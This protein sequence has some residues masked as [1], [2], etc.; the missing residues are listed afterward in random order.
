MQASN[1]SKT[2]PR[3]RR[4]ARGAREFV[5]HALVQDRVLKKIYPGIMHFLL[6]WGVT[7]QIL[8]TI[9]NLLQQ[10]LFL[11]FV[12]NFPRGN[13]YLGF[14][15]IMDIAGG[16]ILL[17]GLMALFRRVA[18]RPKTLESHWDDWYAIGLLLLIPILGFSSEGFRILVTQPEWR[19]WAPIGNLFAKGFSAIH[20]EQDLINPVHQ[21]L[22]WAH[23]VSGLVFVGSIPFTKLRH[24]VNGPLNIVLRPERPAAALEPIENIEEAEKLGVGEVDEFQPFLM[25]NFDA[26]VQCGRCEEVCPSN[27]S[28]MPYSP[29]V[30]IRDIRE[31]VH[32]T[33]I[34]PDGDEGPA[35]LNGALDK[36]IPWYCTTCGACIEVCPLF[37]NPVDS[38]IELRRYLTLTTGEIPGAVGEALMGMERRG[39]PWSMP[40]ENHAPW[41]KEL[42]V[43]ILQPGDEVDVLLFIGCAFG[44]DTRSQKAG[45]ELARILQRAGVDFGV[46]GP[47]EVCCGETAR[48]LGH[49]Y[50]FQVMVEENIATFNSVS[51]NSMVTAC[52]HC[53][54]TLKNEYPQFGG[55]YQV[56]HHTEL[57]AELVRE[58]RIKTN[59]KGG[60][61][62]FSYHDS[63]YL[64]RYNKIFD[65]PRQILHSIPGL[66][67]SEFPRK[68]QNAFC[69]GG[70]GGH[71]W[72]E[73]DPATRINHRRLEEVME[74]V[75]ADTI[76]TACPYCLIM[77]EDAINS[78]GIGE[79]IHTMDI[80]EVISMH[81]DTEGV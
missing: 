35:L 3:L 78:K 75:H 48:R 70:G 50:L 55:K 33:L 69:C 4:W 30:L 21:V 22:F 34:H 26:C 32:S 68:K 19:Q 39:N 36:E 52:A 17:G 58:G 49:E 71:M 43:R 60:E 1:T 57:M 63:C 79:T 62:L 8:G 54:N 80:S 40:K 56:L 6:F 9:I 72:M 10:E 42:G 28:G 81:M 44:Y 5:V 41:V 65:A 7:I 64:G 47:A 16:M 15:L 23:V 67:L 20:I 2:S 37:I 59:A 11:P 77:F 13:A 31:A 53:F 66:R 24:L 76:V 18:L 51:F 45:Y 38:V 27:F 61:R 29:R 12:I 74:H 73:I 14:E 25:L 46:L